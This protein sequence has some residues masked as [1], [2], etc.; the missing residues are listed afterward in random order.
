MDLRI[1]WLYLKEVCTIIEEVMS[2]SDGRLLIDEERNLSFK[3]DSKS[4]IM[5]IINHIG[6]RRVLHE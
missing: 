4:G 5:I 2:K 1:G 3:W 6:R